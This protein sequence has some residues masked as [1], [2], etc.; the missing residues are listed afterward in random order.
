MELKEPA[1]VVPLPLSEQILKLRDGYEGLTYSYD[2]GKKILEYAPNKETADR[3]NEQS[4]ICKFAD[5]RG[6]PC[7]QNDKFGICH[8]FY[9]SVGGIFNRKIEKNIWFYSLEK[10]RRYLMDSKLV[11][12]SSVLYDF[13]DF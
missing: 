6:K 5:K 3:L 4:F 11:C 13:D 2:K 10:R 9:K 12:F 1:D 7:F 8:V